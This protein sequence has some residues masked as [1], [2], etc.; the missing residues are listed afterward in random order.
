MATNLE[1]I[2]SETATSVTSIDVTN[3][4]SSKYDVYAIT[5]T[6]LD[7]SVGTAMDLR[8]IDSGGVD[9]DSNYDFARLLMYA[10]TSFSEQGRT[11]QTF[12]RGMGEA[13]EQGNGN[14]FY[15]FNPFS[16]SEYTFGLGQSVGI[17]GTD[18][19]GFK[20]V[21]VKRETTQYTGFQLFTSTPTTL[22]N[23]DVS[24]YGVK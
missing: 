24:V 9:S 20:W 16:T 12:M 5:Y 13:T 11:N 3:C 1:F 23:I 17:A 18:M 6:M 10:H 22:S 2:K 8:L 15:I 7:N 4:F 21:G 14:W 19:L